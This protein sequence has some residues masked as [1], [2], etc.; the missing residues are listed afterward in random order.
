MA[1]F[2]V[3]VSDPKSKAYQFDVTGAEANKFIGKAIGETVDGE[4]VGLPG[5]TLE[6]TGGSDNSGF[7]M[8]KDLPGPKRQK[9]LVAGG[10]GYSPKANGARRRKFLRGREIAPDI[11]QI[12]SKVV[13]Y[14]GKSIE[15]ILGGGS[16]E[17]VE[18][19]AEE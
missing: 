13:E 8:R 3:V 19:A 16:E 11:V 1:D 15:D 2:K 10:V 7:V 6:I 14:G 12:N 9:V 5:Y 4:V 17:E 18:E